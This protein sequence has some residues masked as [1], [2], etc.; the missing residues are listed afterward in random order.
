MF[1]T[2]R[3]AADF[4]AQRAARL[5]G[6]RFL[7]RP[8]LV[9]MGF[10][11]IGA[12]RAEKAYLIIDAIKQPATARQPTWIALSGWGGLI[13]VPTGQP[14][15]EVKAGQ[16]LIDH[17]DFDKNGHI[18]FGKSFSLEEGGTR[19][20]ASADAI[21]HVGVLQIGPGDE[22]SPLVRMTVVPRVEQL[23][24]ACH[25]HAELLARLP[26]RLGRLK[27]KAKLLRVRCEAGPESIRESVGDLSADGEA[28]GAGAPP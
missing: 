3:L 14:L 18:G 25:S 26:V 12:V 13:H 23:E 5:H 28:A 4:A 20:D 2:L 19:I 1:S 17:V 15:V 6:Y 11:A 24:W 8:I 7:L 16:Y 22:F 9:L 27:S 10:F 21:T